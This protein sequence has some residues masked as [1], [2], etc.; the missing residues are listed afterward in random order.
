M[1]E[2]QEGNT[3]SCGHAVT[4]FMLA[5]VVHLLFLKQ[6]R[7]PVVLEKEGIPF[8]HAVTAAWYPK[9]CCDTSIARARDSVGDV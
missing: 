2:L 3:C 4:S 8:K 5:S 9:I 6:I 1:V 7:A